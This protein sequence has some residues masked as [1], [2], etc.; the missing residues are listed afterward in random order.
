MR[1]YS[2]AEAEGERL[3]LLINEEPWNFKDAIAEKVW[4]D[5]CEDTKNN[6]WDLVD[7]PE[8]A[9][10]IGLKWIFKIKRNT[11]GSINKYKLRFVAKFYIK[12]HGIDFEDVFA[13]VA[14]KLRD[15]L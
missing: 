14:R 8:V 11:E 10:S 1:D 3:L 15:L 7:L 2:L 12:I 5:A 6:T 13:L 4:K 9:K